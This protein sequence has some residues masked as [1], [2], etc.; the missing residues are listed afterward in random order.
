MFCKDKV[1]LLFL[2]KMSFYIMAILYMLLLLL[3]SYDCSLP[4]KLEELWSN[5]WIS[6]INF[7]I[8]FVKLK[9]N[10]YILLL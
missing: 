7:E 2:E 3:L 6:F 10:L 8:A 9:N 4:Y 5:H 1:L